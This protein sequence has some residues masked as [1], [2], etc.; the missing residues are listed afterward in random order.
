MRRVRALVLSTT[1][2]LLAVWWWM[3]DAAHEVATAHAL[4][5]VERPLQAVETPPPSRVG[6]QPSPRVL[7]PRPAPVPGPAE[8]PTAVREAGPLPFFDGSSDATK[9]FIRRNI[10]QLQQCYERMLKEGTIPHRPLMVQTNLQLVRGPESAF[11]EVTIS[12]LG[13]P[14]DA[15]TNWVDELEDCLA[16]RFGAHLFAP[17]SVESRAQFPFRFSPGVEDTGTH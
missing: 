4:A 3:P 7:P 14:E 13:E 10:G 15:D 12:P 1:V 2:A 8:A 16:T 9:D 17:D 6:P 5:P 11:F